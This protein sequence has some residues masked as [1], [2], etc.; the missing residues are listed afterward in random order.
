MASGIVCQILSGK[1]TFEELKKLYECSL[2]EQKIM[3][4]KHEELVAAHY[5][6]ASMRKGSKMEEGYM[7]IFDEGWLEIGYGEG[8]SVGVWDGKTLGIS[9]EII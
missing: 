3:Q 8:I 4:T 2:I 1:E 7:G 5:P 6:A 9:T